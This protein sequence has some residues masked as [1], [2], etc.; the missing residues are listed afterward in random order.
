MTRTIS[1]LT[2]PLVKDLVRLR[3]E[4]SMRLER[5]SVL[6][7]GR[8]MIAEVSGV[9]KLIMTT[10]LAHIPEG[11]DATEVVLATSEVLHK[12]AGVESAE[13][14]VAEIAMPQ[15][16]SLVGLR[17]V[18]A[19]DGI[20]DPGNLGTLLRT[21]LAFGW[22]GV[23]LLDNCC[24]PYNDKALRSAMGAT[25][26]LPMR[27]GLAKELQLLAAAEGWHCYV[28]DLQGQRPETITRKQSLLLILGSEAHGPSVECRQFAEA[29]TL[30][31]QGPMESLN[32]SIAGGIL[33]YLLA[34]A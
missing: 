33:M 30:P 25:L 11:V 32:V 16:A 20:S 7:Q 29:V 6:I 1:S 34:D 9:I 23:F 21:A 15:F 12:V 14:I 31:M 2:H 22:Q 8:K 3:Q 19:L 13:G 27:L 5:K 26:R 18:L 10:D 17:R 4:R 28:A 24:D